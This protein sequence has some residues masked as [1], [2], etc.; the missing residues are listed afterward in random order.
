MAEEDQENKKTRPEKPCEEL[1]SRGT[2]EMIETAIQVYLARTRREE[3]ISC[4]D[5]ED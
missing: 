4:D 5:S 2:E 3:R 1:P